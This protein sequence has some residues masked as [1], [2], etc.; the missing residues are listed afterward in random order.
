M[1][2]I[3]THPAVPL[4]VGVALGTRVVPPRLL[5]TGVVLSILPDLDVLAFRLGIA[6]ADTL[7]NRGFSHSLLFAFMATFACATAYR[8]MRTRFQIALPFLLIAA[9]SHGVLDAFTNGGMGIAFFW[10]WWD[11]RFFAPV[12]PIEVSPIGFARFFSARG[13]SV[14]ASEVLWVWLPLAALGLG[15]AATRRIRAPARPPA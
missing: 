8:P 6:Y 5:L 12:R 7:G 2:T 13:A 10:P 15:L 9:V 1:P 11:A 4:A 14:M 3:L